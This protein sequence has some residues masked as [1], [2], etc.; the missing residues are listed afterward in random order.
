MSHGEFT[1]ATLTRSA[2]DLGVDG[3]E[4]SCKALLAEAQCKNRTA[5]QVDA[6]KDV[7]S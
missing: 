2:S 5:G 1:R 7:V 3:K 6:S 4:G